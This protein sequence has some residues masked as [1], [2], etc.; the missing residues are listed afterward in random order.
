MTEPPSGAPAPV[1][2]ELRDGEE[3]DLR[4]LA[5]EICR[6]YR[7]E[8]PDEQARYGD[9]GWRG[10]YTTTSTCSTGQWPRQTATA[11][12]NGN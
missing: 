1:T 7:Y 5:H 6:R 11:G 9:A 3:L 8:F 10:A 4:A 12:S 2:A